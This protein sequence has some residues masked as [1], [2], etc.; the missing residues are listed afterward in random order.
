MSKWI[1][2]AH[3]GELEPDSGKHIELGEHVI[4]LFYHDDAYY[5]LDGHCPH[6]GGPLGLGSV[7]S[8]GYVT[9][10]LHAWEFDLRSGVSPLSPGVAVCT[11]RVRVEDGEIQVLL[12]P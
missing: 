4:A 11:Y 12:H 7:T 10:P 3:E 8:D 5:A 1:A 9:C 2:V 6:Q